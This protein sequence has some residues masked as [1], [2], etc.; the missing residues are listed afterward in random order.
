VESRDPRQVDRINDEPRRAKSEKRKPAPEWY[1][2]SG[3]RRNVQNRRRTVTV[4]FLSPYS[5]T[6]LILWIGCFAWLAAGARTANQNVRVSGQGSVFLR[7]FKILSLVCLFV[8][9][10]CPQWVHLRRPAENRSSVI[11]LVG[12]LL[13][14]A[15]ISL[16]IL[17]RRALG[18]NWSDL[19]VVKS[20]HEVV[21]RGPYHWV[22]HP[23]YVGGILGFLG[24][25]LTVGTPAA[26]TVVAVCFV[27]LFV[28]SRKEEALLSQQLPGYASYKRRVKA[29]IPFVL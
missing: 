14:L 3:Y 23:L 12:L 17:A 1:R 24:S 8:V 2:N 7:I 16:L 5:W 9:I 4:A 26:Y 10:Y 19:V 28:K 29:F 13:C 18:R 21:Q 25:A 6:T 27:G 11:G 20:D 15:G 22:R